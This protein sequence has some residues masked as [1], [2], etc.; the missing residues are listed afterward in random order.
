MAERVSRSELKARLREAGG[1]TPRELAEAIGAEVS[2]SFKRALAELVDE[3]VF[4]PRGSTR[5]RFYVLAGSEVEAPEPQVDGRELFKRKVAAGVETFKDEQGFWQC[6]LRED[7]AVVP[8][9]VASGLGAAVEKGIWRGPGR[10][11]A[12]GRMSARAGSDG[13][14][15]GSG[16]PP[17]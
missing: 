5:D 6:R 1:G 15:I 16:R 13:R 3:G 8:G 12:F 17:R 4:E 11:E 7:E 14:I 2:G 10:S 9:P